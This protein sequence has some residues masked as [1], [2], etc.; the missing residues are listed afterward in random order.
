M[1][2]KLLSIVLALCLACGTAASPYSAGTTYAATGISINESY[3]PDSQFRSYVKKFDIYKDNQ[4]SE[5]EIKKVT[6]I[7]VSNQSIAS[8]DGIKF[9]TAL[10][11]LI[12]NSNQLE[13]LDVSKNTAL[14]ELSCS[15]NKL[16]HLDVSN[17]TA[18]KL[19]SCSGNQLVNLDVSNNTVL[20]QLDCSRN[21]L[22]NLDVSNNT[23]LTKL[24]CRTNKLSDL[25]LSKNTAL[26]ELCC[27]SNRLTELKLN[28]QTYDQLPLLTISLNN[29]LSHS[30]YT[31]KNITLTDST[32]KVNDI[33]RPATYKYK[34][35]SQ[36]KSF[37]IIYADTLGGN[38]G[39]PE[40]P[41][42]AVPSG[43][44]IFTDYDYNNPVTDCPVIYGNGITQTI[45][46]NK[47]SNKALTVYTDILASYKYTLNNGKVKPSVGKVIVAV[48][49][50]S[51]KPVVDSRNRVTDKSAAQI[52][53]AKIKNGQITVTA[54]GKEGGIVYLWVIDTGSK[55]VSAYCPINVKLAPKKLEVQDMSDNSRLRNVMLC[56]G[57]TL[58]V[59]M[60]GFV[61]DLKT[62]DCTYTATVDSKY[63]NYI[64][65]TPIDASKFAIKA[66]GLKNGRKTKV[67]VTFKCDQNGKKVKFPLTITP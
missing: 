33:T 5:E 31:S 47:V 37:T 59:C 20:K 18:L 49:K 30:V 40:K 34:D 15:G 25:D 38:T 17:N 54:A 21:S 61:S 12:C 1:K 46:G 58:R 24:D 14:I 29:I 62:D 55:G 50:S 39:D 44:R 8:L 42:P 11:S 45:D 22:L 60:T 27:H 28:S 41:G 64:S 9:F 7:D 65:V 19:L 10:E 57:E 16:S 36:D 43:T 63:Q 2:K 48:T 3:F 13:S 32:L 67:A 66:T 35:G 53:K 23:A 26:A 4:L 6:Q 56:D 52:A 51:E